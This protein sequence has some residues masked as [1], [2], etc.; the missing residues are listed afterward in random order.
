MRL[1]PAEATDIPAITAIYNEVILNSTAVY[2]LG[3]FSQADRLAWFEARRG[4]GFPILAAEENGEL[5]GFSTF[6]LW[7]GSLTDAYQHTVEHTVHIR[8]GQRGKGLGGAL[9][10]ALFPLA[11]QMNKHVMIGAIDADNSGS[12]RF[13]ERHGFERT[14]RIRQVGRKF[15][16]WL[17]LVFMQ[18]IL[19]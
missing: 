4:L 15:G 1:R 8:P 14:G 3:P 13:H 17:D 2:A 6:G 5:L 18:K 10:E 16:R 12:I 7:R 9:L 11:V 19:D